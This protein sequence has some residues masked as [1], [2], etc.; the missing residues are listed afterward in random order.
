MPAAGATS[1]QQSQQ[2]QQQRH[3]PRPTA[4]DGAAARRNG[5]DG[6]GSGGRSPAPASLSA[7]AR[8]FTPGTEPCP[9]VA[10]SPTEAAPSPSRRPPPPPQQQQQPTVVL[11]SR[12]KAAAKAAEEEKRRKAEAEAAAAA[13]KALREAEAAEE[14]ERLQKREADAVAAAAAAAAAA[15]TEAVRAAAEAAAT[16]KAERKAEKARAKAAKKEEERGSGKRDPP[17]ATPAPPPPP[18]PPPAATS[19][20]RWELCDCA[21]LELALRSGPANPLGPPGAVHGPARALVHALRCCPPGAPLASLAQRC[22]Q[23]LA[24]AVLGCGP[25]APAPLLYWWSNAA[26]LRAAL[27]LRCVWEAAEEPPAALSAWLQAACARVEGAAC[28]RAAGAAWDLACAPACAKPPAPPQR[29]HSVD[30][31]LAAHWLGALEG[32]ERALAGGGAAAGAAAADG[33]TGTF[34]QLPPQALALL[35]S[36]L[37]VALFNALLRAPGGS[38]SGGDGS[39]SDGSDPVSQRAAV[40]GGGAVTFAAGVAIK[41]AVQALSGWA[42]QR[43]VPGSGGKGGKSGGGGG[44]GGGGAT[45]FP[46]MRCAADVLMMPKGA[47]ADAGVRRDVAGALTPRLLRQLLGRFTPDDSAPEAVPQTLLAALD[48]E[49]RKESRKASSRGSDGSGGPS[50]APLAPLPY[51]PVDASALGCE[52]LDYDGFPL[53]EQGLVVAADP[54]AAL[55]GAEATQAAPGATPDLRFRA[56]RQAW[57]V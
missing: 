35:L 10:A 37:D 56:L 45:C 53:D 22:A 44:G 11:P 30:D 4:G 5:S 54:L 17:A 55:T 32:A 41:L 24:G 57:G 12:A 9:P 39:S 23:A 46:L 25:S 8:P 29:G 34:P 49:A 31:A 43:R 28:A 1:A 50:L 33:G 48:S 21:A 15:A 19:E 14:A 2:Q 7:S 26:A 16:A 47:L 20:E 36:R 51:A 6:N 42:A 52:W 13:E 40:P 27:S 3:D 38:A 18:P